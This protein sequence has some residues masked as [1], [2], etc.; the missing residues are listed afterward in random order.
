MYERSL[1]ETGID[2]LLYERDL[3]QHCAKTVE[4]KRTRAKESPSLENKAE[5]YLAIEGFLLHFRNLLG[6][7]INKRMAPTDLTINRPK[8]WANGR[9]IDQ[10]LCTKLT[11]KA[12][13]VNR[14]HGLSQA[15]DCYKKISWFLQH[16]TEHRYQIR[17]AWDLAGMFTDFHSIVNEFIE[18]VTSPVAEAKETFILGA[19]DHSTATITKQR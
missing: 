12:A 5:Y 13:S 17:R 7:F 16:C 9:K 14:K 4:A 3:L 8:N 15:V 18:S 2:V 10:T 6:F 11:S 1:K 19:V